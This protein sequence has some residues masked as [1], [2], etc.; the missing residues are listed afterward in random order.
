MTKKWLF[1]WMVS[2][3]F[4]IVGTWVI[5]EQQRQGAIS[6]NLSIPTVQIEEPS[7][8]LRDRLGTIL[9]L[10]ANYQ[11]SGS[12]LE[13][14]KDKQVT[15]ILVDG[16]TPNILEQLPASANGEPIEVLQIDGAALGFCE[17][18]DLAG[19]LDTASTAIERLVLAENSDCTSPHKTITIIKLSC[20]QKLLDCLASHP[21]TILDT[22]LQSILYFPSYPTLALTYQS[23]ILSVESSNG[24]YILTWNSF[25][26]EIQQLA[27][28]V[29]ILDSQSKRVY[30]TGKIST[31]Y[32][33]DYFLPT[34]QLAS[35]ALTA[36]VRVWEKHNNEKAGAPLIL[37]SQFEY[38]AYAPPLV[39]PSSKRPVQMSW[40]PDWGMSSGI[41]SITKNPD[42]WHTVSPVWF[43]PNSNGTINREPTIN[44]ASLLALAKREKIRLVPTISSFDADI[45]SALLNKNLDR[46]V[47]EIVSVVEKN[48]YAGI[49]L[50]YESTYEKDS[51]LLVEFL[52]KLAEKLHQKNKT[53]SFTALPKIDDRRIYSFLPQ[54]HQ[55]QNWQ[56]IG[57][58]VDEFRIMAY[59]FTGQGSA[60]PGPLSPYQWNEALIR[61]A[62]SKMPAE[63]IVLALPL[64]S[65]GW[66]KPSNANLAGVNNDRSLSSGKQKNTISLQHDDIAYIKSHSQNYSETYDT[67]NKEI[68]ATFTYNGVARI[69][70]YLDSR[71]VNERLR[72][73][74]QYGIKGVCYWRIGGESL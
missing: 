39:T 50:D 2:I 29:E 28:S 4:I 37:T 48:N 17:N 3:P 59:D 47:N 54:T 1:L 69:M 9:I 53:L 18:S 8:A 7:T 74:Q 14:I 51:A 36:K 65:H 42:K 61:Y 46:H 66:P 62:L 73:A 70:Y 26:P 58:I 21:I 71:A 16:A 15:T 41:T 22:D 19:S 24:M 63:K 30:A 5:E 68:R 40:I 32:Q 43:T 49:D 31:P 56:A 64:Y 38:V 55:A 67:W 60:Q 34:R 57:A 12:E 23:P 35:Q 13:T 45:I 10:P 33:G 27:Y 25:T 6:S 11:L 72:L 44:N 20:S 52:T